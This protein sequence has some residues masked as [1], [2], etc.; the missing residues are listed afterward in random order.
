MLSSSNVCLNENGKLPYNGCKL[1]FQRGASQKESAPS[2]RT[3]VGRMRQN[4]VKRAHEVDYLLCRAHTFR[5]VP[6]DKHHA[7]PHLQPRPE[8]ISFTLSPI[9]SGTGKGV[10]FVTKRLTTTRSEPQRTVISSRRCSQ[11]GFP[12][13]KAFCPVLHSILR[14]VPGSRS[15]RTSPFGR[16]REVYSKR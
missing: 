5:K 8:S 14:R 6:N 15:V 10:W 11:R 7:L 3:S 2:R 12:R 9:T 4:A 1:D 16:T 13:L